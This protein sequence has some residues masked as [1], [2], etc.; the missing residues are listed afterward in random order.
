MT[1]FLTRVAFYGTRMVDRLLRQTTTRNIMHSVN[2]LVE[3][4]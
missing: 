4:K 1:Y 2:T 3:T